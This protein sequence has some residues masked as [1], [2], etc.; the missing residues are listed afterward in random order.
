M[1]GTPP[2]PSPFQSALRLVGLSVGALAAGAFT[3]GLV[4]LVAR[5]WVG[6][7]Q[8]LSVLALLVGGTGAYLYHRHH[9]AEQRRWQLQMLARLDQVDVMTGPEFEELTAELLRRDGFRSVR[10]LGGSG[11][12]GVDITALTP[13]GRRV[14]VQ[15]KRKKDKVFPSQV[16]ELAGALVCTYRDHAG[17]F[18]T[19]NYFS[20]Q[21]QAEARGHMTLVNR[22]TLA[23]WLDGRELVL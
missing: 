13:D 12:R 16:R 10:I 1:D 8:F 9:E 5:H 17:V 4:Y 2:A 6:I 21:A 19:N 22:A 23:G 7:L 14:A 3:T 18:V 11:D 20:E 15:C